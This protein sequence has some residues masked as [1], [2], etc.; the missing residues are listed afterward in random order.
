LRRLPERRVESFHQCAGAPRRPDLPMRR[1][2]NVV[3]HGV[4]LAELLRG[5]GIRDGARFLWA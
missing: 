4:D 1:I 5:C 2:G 3:W